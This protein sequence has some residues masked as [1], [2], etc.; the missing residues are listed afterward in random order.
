MTENKFY[1]FT[2]DGYYEG[3]V[4]AAVDPLETKK[5]GHPVYIHPCSA[6]D[7]EPEKKDGFWPRW[8]DGA[9]TYVRLPKTVDDLVAF[10]RIKHD[11]T[12][13]FWR[14]MNTIRTELVQANER[15]KSELQDGY[16]I[17]SQLPEPTPEEILER[18]AQEIRSK[19]DYLISKTD[20]LV[21]GDYPISD[22]DLS[23]V[24]R[25]RQALRDVPAQEGFPDSVVWPELPQVTVIRE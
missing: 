1:R 25:Y 15:C 11:Q 10:G 2:P 9:W 22:A 12:I 6:T 20:Y 8:Q 4:G 23:A 3:E 14:Q 7:V 13:G 5:A 19:R 21:S 24:R 18:Q 16:W 17:V